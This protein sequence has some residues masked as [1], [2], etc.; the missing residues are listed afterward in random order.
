MHEEQNN[1]ELNQARG[2]HS[3]FGAGVRQDGQTGVGDARL[4]EEN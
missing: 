3:V 2:E 4:P 1:S